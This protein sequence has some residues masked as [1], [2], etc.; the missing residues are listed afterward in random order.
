MTRTQL[1][2]MTASMEKFCLKW[3]DF[4]QNI[5][6]SYKDLRE[7]VDF[8]DVTLVSEDDQQVEAHRV[9]LSGCSTFFKELLKK[10]KHSHPM[11]YMRK[12]N[13]KNLKAI[14]DFIYYGET[15]ISQEDLD[16]FLSLAE[17]LQLKGLAAEDK[18]EEN[19]GYEHNESFQ[20]VKKEPIKYNPA[21]V[22]HTHKDIAEAFR[23]YDTTVYKSDESPESGAVVVINDLNS[24]A[25]TNTEELVNQINS[26]MQKVEGTKDWS[27]T[28][29]GKTAG[30]KN[31]LR[32][33]IEAN[34]I[35]G[36]SHRCDQCGKVSRSTHGLRKHKYDTH[37]Q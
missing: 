37:K 17:E 20:D 23:S 4:R 11:I 3:N 16:S 34:H 2:K 21:K 12:V 6:T 8:S 28:V 25:V 5:A 35:E 22:N 9:I 33:H 10:T 26:M 27:C 18:K 13:A 30:H 29:C 19:K 31:N 7:N 1:H 15:N 24:Y 36:I 14:L 32:Q